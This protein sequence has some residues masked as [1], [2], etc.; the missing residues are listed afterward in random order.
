VTVA[1]ASSP[2]FFVRAAEGD[3]L[4]YIRKTW[5]QEHAQHSTWI[6]DVGGGRVYFAE[7]KRALDAALERG[8]ATIAYR[9]AV[10][11]GICGFAVTEAGVVHFVYTKPRWRR[12]GAARLLLAP[13]RDKPALYTHRTTALRHLPVP[14]S[15]T[16]N[17]Y[18]FLRHS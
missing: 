11:E 8:A 18:P 14:A 12:L 2:E 17:P 4:N 9:P 7:H 16:F 10:P 5:L 6:D 13:L 1:L 15:W 3:D